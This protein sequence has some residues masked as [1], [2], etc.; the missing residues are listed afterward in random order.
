[1][2][3]SS[4]SECC[5]SSIS[6]A[7]SDEGT[8]FFVCDTCRKS[9]DPQSNKPKFG[10]NFFYGKIK[11]PTH[12]LSQQIKDMVDEAYN[13][14][15]DSGKDDDR[16][17]DILNLSESNLVKKDLILPLLSQAEQRG[18]DRA[19]RELSIKYGGQG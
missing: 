19:K 12:G 3:S 17:V 16:I 11:S 15:L 9:C 6:V 13:A 14:N 4:V 7:G 2:K 5:K 10:K 18:Y 1:M 8:M